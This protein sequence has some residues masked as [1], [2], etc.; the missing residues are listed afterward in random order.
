[1]TTTDDAP[2]PVEQAYLQIPVPGVP[3]SAIRVPLNGNMEH[4][5]LWI[6]HAMLI[7]QLAANHYADAFPTAAPPPQEAPQRP[8]QAQQ[9][10]AQPRKGT[11]L[12]PRLV[13]RG[14]CPQHRAPAKP[15]KLEYQEIEMDEEGNER[16]AKYYCNAGERT[17][18]L[19]ARQLVQG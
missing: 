18:S 1:M 7:A 3:Y 19:Y 4:D 6:E 11:E 12:D 8:P 17:H 14:D 2:F 13:V 10:A 5:N 16:Y 9:Q 15:S